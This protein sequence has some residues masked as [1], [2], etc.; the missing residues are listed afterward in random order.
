MEKDKE[1]V[2]N[3]VGYVEPGIQLV[4]WINEPKTN[5]GVSVYN[6][7]SGWANVKRWMWTHTW[8]TGLW[9]ITW[10]WFQP[11][12]VVINAWS[13]LIESHTSWDAYS[14]WGRSL[15]MNSASDLVTQSP[16][17]LV[18]FLEDDSPV[19]D[20]Y[21]RWNA[22]SLDSDWFTINITRKDFNF[23]YEWQAFG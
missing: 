15:F 13:G 4:K 11:K 2:P 8:W 5:A 10:L 14:S 21:V 22:S 1:H 3:S 16:V 9:S 18:I 6:I 20:I 23:H 19:P 12:M 17:P 7:P